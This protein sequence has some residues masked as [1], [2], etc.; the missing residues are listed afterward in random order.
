MFRL[1]KQIRRNRRKK[2]NKKRKDLTTT[3][4][5]ELDLQISPNRIVVNPIFL[6]S[7]AQIDP[8]EFPNFSDL[9]DSQLLTCLAPI[10]LEPEL[11]QNEVELTIKVADVSYTFS[12]E[13][14]GILICFWGQIKFQ[15][16]LDIVTSIKTNLEESSE[17]SAKTT[18]IGR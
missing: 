5:N 2:E 15:Q 16:V 10:E 1:L 3:K 13:M 7:Q 18:F 4:V 12:Q 11:I 8:G 17:K 9:N 14:E 6:I